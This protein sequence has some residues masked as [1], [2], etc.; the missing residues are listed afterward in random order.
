MGK[1]AVMSY[2]ILGISIGLVGRRN[3]VTY[4]ARRE[5][6]CHGE[7]GKDK[8]LSYNSSSQSLWAPSTWTPSTTRSR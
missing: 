1:C 2:E 6:D 4:A 3:A 7:L 5:L 8:R